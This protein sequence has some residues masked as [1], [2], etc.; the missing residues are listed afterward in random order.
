MGHTQNH[1]PGVRA[2]LCIWCVHL[3]VCEHMHMCESTCIRVHV[4]TCVYFLTA[5][6][7]PARWKTGEVRKKDLVQIWGARRPLPLPPLPALGLAELPLL[8]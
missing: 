3:C 4:C 8:L 1:Q 5:P 7:D 6:Q 2:Q